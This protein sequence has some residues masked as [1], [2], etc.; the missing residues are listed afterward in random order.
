MR[1]A[2]LGVERMAVDRA[3]GGERVRAAYN[4]CLLGATRMTRA[5]R[6]EH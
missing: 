1:R 3:G 5:L 2:E 6:L 4:P